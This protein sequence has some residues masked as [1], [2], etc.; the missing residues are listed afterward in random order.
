[1]AKAEIDDNNPYGSASSLLAHGGPLFDAIRNSA[2]N[3]LKDY[4]PY[5]DYHDRPLYA[6]GDQ[7]SSSVELIKAGKV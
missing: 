3:A 4:L 2:L 6:N 5:T 1:M 7:L